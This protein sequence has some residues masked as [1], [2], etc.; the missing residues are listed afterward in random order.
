MVLCGARSV[1]Y[2]HQ[3][4]VDLEYNYSM[5][6][7]FVHA[8][9]AEGHSGDIERRM[10]SEMQSPAHSQPSREILEITFFFN[11]H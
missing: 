1:R 5:Q 2:N 4:S 3:Y 8:R 10:Y 11:W 6:A 9:K 7:V